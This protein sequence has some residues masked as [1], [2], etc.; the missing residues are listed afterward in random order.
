LKGDV[1]DGG[2]SKIR[3]GKIYGHMVR[4]AE[5]L[6]NEWLTRQLHTDRGRRLDSLQGINDSAKAVS[7]QTVAVFWHQFKLVSNLLKRLVPV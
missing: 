5:K 3:Y 6:I 1:L 4:Q 7:I 2:V